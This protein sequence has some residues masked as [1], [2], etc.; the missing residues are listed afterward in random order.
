MARGFV[1]AGFVVR[2]HTGKT[3]AKGRRL[4][5]QNHGQLAGLQFLVDPGLGLQPVHGINEQSLHTPRQHVLN[6]RFF[7]LQEIEGMGVKQ[8]V[9]Q[10]VGQLISSLHASPQSEVMRQ[11]KDTRAGRADKR[12]MQTEWRPE[13]LQLA[14]EIKRH[15]EARGEPVPHGRPDHRLGLA[16]RPA[17][18]V[19]ER[20]LR[21]A[22][23]PG[24]PRGRRARPGPTR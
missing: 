12:M 6:E 10:F 15:A 24:R 13:S 11:G 4:A 19:R 23:H 5:E 20:A 22:P 18:R 8:V 2:R 21:R 14:Q 16:P 3:A 17:A 7:A 1:T 9:A